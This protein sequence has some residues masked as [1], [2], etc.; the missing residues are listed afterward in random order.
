MKSCT[1]AVFIIDA[2]Q[3]SD[4][5]ENWDASQSFLFHMG[6]ASV[7]Y[8][9]KVLL[10]VDAASARP[11]YE[12]FTTVTFDNTKIEDSGMDLVLA[13]NKAGIIRVVA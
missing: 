8:G 6:A 5:D 12:A 4:I 1:A 10:Y 13:L 3:D 2:G 11:G 7:L 9:E